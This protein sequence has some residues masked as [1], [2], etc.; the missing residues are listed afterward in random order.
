[1][2]N[3][4]ELNEL[5]KQLTDQKEYLENKTK[6]NRNSRMDLSQRDSVSELSAYD[7]HPADLGTELFERQK[8]VALDLHEND[9]LDQ[10]NAALEEIE[11]GEYGICKECGKEIPYERLEAVPYTLY[12][13]E[14]TPDD[15][16]DT[17]R[18]VEEDILKPSEVN[19]FERTYD[20]RIEDHN[21]SFQE[22]ARYGTSETPAD[23][24]R[25][26]DDYNSIYP[27]ENDQ[28]GFTEDIESF[29]GNTIDGERHIYPNETQE[30]YEKQLDEEDVESTMG[31]IPYHKSDGYVNKEKK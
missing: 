21:D 8:D 1:M 7:N 28:D 2:L 27:E 15:S 29:V 12:C 25:D 24:T 14:H 20:S 22:V 10:I 6:S 26:I 5:K 30:E 9:Q 11:K 18:P 4:E 31:D 19:S 17:D 13:V 3:K 23:T 16:I